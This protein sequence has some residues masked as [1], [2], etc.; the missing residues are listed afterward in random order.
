MFEIGWT[1]ILFI[2]LVAILV[3]KPKDYPEMMRSIG[4]FLAKA[5]TM[6]ADFQG[7]FNEAMKDANLQDV[8]KTIDEIRD[9]KNMGPIQQVKDTFVQMADEAAKVR[10]E[11]KGVTTGS[12][13][14]GVQPAA[15]TSATAV[16]APSAPPPSVTAEPLP[17]LPAVSDV[18]AGPP[19][20]L[21]PK[22][23]DAP[24]TAAP[25]WPAPDAGPTKAA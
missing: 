2:G 13:I 21:L 10:D 5:R 1:E 7:Q 20:E 17:G 8:K 9:L 24:S 22:P 14:P 6:A 16:E 19:A 4:Q 23:A 12:G 15:S 25:P 18:P 3:L 11:V